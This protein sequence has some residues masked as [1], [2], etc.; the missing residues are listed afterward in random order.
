VLNP[1]DGS[2]TTFA[3]NI[4]NV[5]DLV[6]A[7]NGS[8]SYIGDCGVMRINYSEHLARSDFN[9]DEHSDL[10]WQNNATGQRAVWVMDGTTWVSERFLPTIPTEWQ[11]ASSGDFDGDRQT[12]LVWQ[13]T[14][15]GQ[16]AIWLMHGTTWVGERFLP[17]IPTEWQIVGTGYFGGPHDS[18][19]DLVWQ[20]TANGRRAI[21]LMAGDR[22]IGERL[23]PTIPVPWQIAGTGDA[24]RD[25][26][27][28]L[29][30]QNTSTGQRAIWLMDQ[31]TWVGER[32]LPTIP[33]EWEIRNR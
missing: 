8:L 26:H 2:V 29:I 30:W 3:T 19:V 25:G 10:I 16:R 28:D 1:A 23:L 12:D 6:V 5:A 11:I 32:F 22:W 18:H 17:T 21:W 33:T 7:P 14:V 4:Q 31:S 20:N 24:N 13:N 9:A 27:T 15:T